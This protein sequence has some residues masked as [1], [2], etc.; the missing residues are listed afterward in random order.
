[1]NFDSIHLRFDSGGVVKPSVVRLSVLEN[2][3]YK[4]PPDSVAA[5]PVSV[6]S[7]ALA[8]WAIWLSVIFGISPVG[9]DVLFAASRSQN[10]I[11]YIGLCLLFLTLMVTP[12][13]LLFLRSGQRAFA[14]TPIRITVSCLIIA[15]YVAVHGSMLIRRL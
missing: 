5:D 9:G 8:T 6:P 14:V 11:Y 4:P 15:L 2:K 12:L 7:T 10:P 13:A 3:P 1:M